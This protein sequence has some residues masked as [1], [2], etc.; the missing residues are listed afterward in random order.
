MRT[1]KPCLSTWNIQYVLTSPTY[2]NI[3]I[4]GPAGL[5]TYVCTPTKYLVTVHRGKLDTQHMY[6]YIDHKCTGLVYNTE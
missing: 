2:D 3:N 5:N 6:M 1:Y 4:N